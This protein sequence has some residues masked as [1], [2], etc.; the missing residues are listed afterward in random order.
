MESTGVE[1]TLRKILSLEEVRKMNDFLEEDICVEAREY[2]TKSG[3]ETP[4]ASNHFDDLWQ[5]RKFVNALYRSGA[6]KV[7][8]SGFFAESWRQETE[9]DV[10][11]DVLLI[12]KPTDRT[13]NVIGKERPDELSKR[14]NWIRLW[15]D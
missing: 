15:W 13:I 11:A 9:G 8:V 5:F 2:I 12:F 14:G 4:F 3:N 10:Y 1:R 7:L 6:E